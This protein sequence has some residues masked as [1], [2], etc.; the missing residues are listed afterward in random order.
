MKIG[1]G[2]SSDELESAEFG[3]S[4][5]GRE[6]EKSKSVESRVGDF[7][8]FLLPVRIESADAFLRYLGGVRN[9]TLCVHSRCN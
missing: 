6:V 5:S 2:V 4:N 8:S 1:F 3:I 9:V 7:G